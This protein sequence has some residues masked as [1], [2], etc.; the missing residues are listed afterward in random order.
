M[1]VWAQRIGPA[2]ADGAVGLPWD[3]VG[4]AAGVGLAAAPPL[5]SDGGSP[6]WRVGPGGVVGPAL[7]AGP[8][9]ANVY[10]GVPQ[11]RERGSAGEA[12]ASAPPVP[13]NNETARPSRGLARVGRTALP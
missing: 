5:P 11:A 8:V 6:I 4:G 2:G 9:Q 7:L 1:G 10:N 13:F 12:Q 3:D